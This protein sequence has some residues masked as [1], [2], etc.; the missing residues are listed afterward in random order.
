M[1]DVFDNAGQLDTQ[2][3]LPDLPIGDYTVTIRD[4]RRQ[5]SSKSNRTNLIVTFDT[6]RGPASWATSL[7]VDSWGKQKGVVTMKRI[8]ALALGLEPEGD[9]ARALGKA[10][11][12]AA[13]SAANPHEG[14]SLRVVCNLGKAKAAPQTGHYVEAH[15]DAA[16]TAA[17]PVAAPVTAPA[18]PDA[19]AG[20]F[21]FAP[22]DRR[23]GKRQYNAAGETRAIA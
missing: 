12:T 8:V 1:T 19:D 16:R 22:T 17:A 23:H 10:D 20:W 13:V 21:D 3:R 7:E 5:S 9:A 14:A 15:F 11:L 4:M 6:P 18:P 2:L